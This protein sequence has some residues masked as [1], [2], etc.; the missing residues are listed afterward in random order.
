MFGLKGGYGKWICS[1]VGIVFMVDLIVMYLVIG[2]KF[3]ILISG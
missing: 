1:N 3:I 2:V